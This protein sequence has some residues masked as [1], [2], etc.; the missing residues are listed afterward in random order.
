MAAWADYLQAHRQRFLHELVQFLTIPSISGAEEHLVHVSAA[1]HWVER[2][3]LQAGVAV[4]RVMAAGTSPV[5]YG[6]GPHVPGRPTVL[7]YGHFDVEPPGRLSHWTFPP[8]SPVVTGDRIYARGASDDKGNMLIPIL[9]AEALL[10]TKGE[11]PVNVKF[12]FEGQ[13]E[14]GSPDLGAFVEQHR[15]LL[16]CDVVLSADGGLAGEDLPAITLSCRGFGALQ[17][18]VEAH[19][20]DLHSGVHGGAV[21]NPI[22]ALVRL[23]D[24]MR[25]PDGTVT[26]EGFYQGVNPTARG[27]AWARPAL[28]VNGIWGGSSGAIIPARA[29]ATLSCRLV[30]RQ[31]PGQVLERL[32]AHLKRWVP[33]DVRVRVSRLGGT[34]RPYCMSAD[35]PA[36][37]AAGAVLEAV[38]GSAPA[39]VGTGA[40]VPIYALFRD[41]LGVDSVTFG[42]G[43]DD[44]NLHAP[45]EFLRLKNWRRGQEAYCR[46]LEVLSR[47]T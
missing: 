33:S 22:H 16:R 14:I 31:E 28:E 13:E 42:F 19:P 5:V 4:V 47:P 35:H 24:S 23:L 26:V 32:E 21:P 2:R 45:D 46:L 15:D 41:L 10:Q 20:A 34:C 36:N 1:A 3:L 6:E 11:L 17:V 30:D 18:E 12:L 9:A 8:F 29:G 38:Y 43:C 39:Y 27:P 40:S 25:G 7:I 44:E 37:R